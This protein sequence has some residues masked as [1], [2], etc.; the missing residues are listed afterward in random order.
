MPLEPQEDLPGALFRGLREAN[1]LGLVQV[2]EAGMTD[3]AYFDAL[4]VLRDRGDLPV[5]SGCSWPAG[6]PTRSGSNT[7]ATLGSRSR[8]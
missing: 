6:W 4:R 5:R 8:A 7:K 2:T 1:K 3:W